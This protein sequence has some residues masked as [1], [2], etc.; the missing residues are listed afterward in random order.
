MR[1]AV[2]WARAAGAIVVS[3]G[4]YLASRVGSGARLGPRPARV[5]RRHRPDRGALALEDVN[6]ASYRAGFLAGDA[7][8]VAELLAVRKHSGLVPF[9]FRRR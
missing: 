5:R 2:A 3:D 8:L 9:Q 4:C 1:A 7:D 6:L